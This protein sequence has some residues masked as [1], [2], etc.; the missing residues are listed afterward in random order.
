MDPGR[1]TTETVF[2]FPLLVD[3]ERDIWGSRSK[4]DNIAQ[5]ERDRRPIVSL[6]VRK[7]S[8]AVTSDSWKVDWKG[9]MT[10]FLDSSR[11]TTD[12]FYVT[13]KSRS[14]GARDGRR[15]SRS[16]LWGPSC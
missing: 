6:G 10:G 15:V 3:W 8:H 14:E 13:K 5:R 9:E 7:K 16:D 1:G 2:H 4:M 11:G 12:R